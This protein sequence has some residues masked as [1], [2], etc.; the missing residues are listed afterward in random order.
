MRLS[1]D[2][3]PPRC[4]ACRLFGFT[5]IIE[6]R[7]CLRCRVPIPSSGTN[8][9]CAK[10]Q[11]AEAAIPQYVVPCLECINNFLA[12]PGVTRCFAC[13]SRGSRV[14]LPPI[15]FGPI[16]LSAF[17]PSANSFGPLRNSYG[18]RQRPTSPLLQTLSAYSERSYDHSSVI[19]Q[20]LG[21]LS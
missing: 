20:S 3:H 10:C 12:Y 19:K 5:P 6:T 18:K 4:P 11:V 7:P 21:F 1:S 13:T 8:P 2:I 17:N 9:N 16:Y 15:N 14:V